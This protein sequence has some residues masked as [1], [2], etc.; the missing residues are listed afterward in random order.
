MHS[1]LNLQHDMPLKMYKINVNHIRSQT[2]S[3]ILWSKWFL[4][5]NIFIVQIYYTLSKNESIKDHIYSIINVVLYC[6]FVSLHW[7]MYFT[8]YSL[9][10]TPS[11]KV[12]M[13]PA[14]AP[15]IAVP[16][17]RFLVVANILCVVS[18]LIRELKINDAATPRRGVNMYDKKKVFWNLM[19]VTTV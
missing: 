8:S 2:P 11:W 10:C 12:C 14:P 5:F 7:Q 13:A 15:C 4:N 1:Y 6:P 17:Y 16:L 3:A 18:V 9:K 19:S